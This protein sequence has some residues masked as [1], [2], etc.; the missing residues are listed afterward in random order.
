M[1]KF[2]G[3]VIYSFTLAT[4]VTMMLAEGSKLYS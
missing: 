4:L 3:I 1:K 2:I